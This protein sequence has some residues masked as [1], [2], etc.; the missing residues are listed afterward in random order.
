MTHNSGAQMSTEPF[1]SKIYCTCSTVF[2]QNIM[3]PP[4]P[5]KKKKKK[6]VYQSFDLK[7][8][9]VLSKIELCDI[10]LNLYAVMS[11]I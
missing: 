2:Q 4:C 1:V 7:K 11:S 9:S 10:T 8:Y 5:A 3:T 6:P